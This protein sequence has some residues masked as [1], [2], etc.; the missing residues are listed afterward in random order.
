MCLDGS[1]KTALPAA[2]RRRGILGSRLG[3]KLVS[4][5]VRISDFTPSGLLNEVERG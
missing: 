2:E 3:P 1:P 4:A 5:F